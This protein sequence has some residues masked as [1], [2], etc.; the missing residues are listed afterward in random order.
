M[1]LILAPME[2]RMKMSIIRGVLNSNIECYKK[3]QEK[4]KE[5]VGDDRLNAQSWAEMKDNLDICYRFIVEGVLSAHESVMSDM[6]TLDG[7]IGNEY[8]DED[9][10]E[11]KKKLLE[12]ECEMYENNLRQLEFSLMA[13]VS[14]IL[15]ASAKE[16]LNAMIERTREEIAV[17]QEKINFL[18][19]AESSTKSLFMSALGLFETVANVIRDGKIVLNKGDVPIEPGWLKA[20]FISDC[21]EGVDDFEEKERVVDIIIPEEVTANINGNSV[22]YHP[23]DSWGVTGGAKPGLQKD[24]DGKYL[25]AVA[26]KIL[27]PDYPDDGK[28]WDDDFAN[29][30]HDIEV[31]L[32]NKVTGEKKVIE[33]VVTDIK[34]H[35]YNKY[36]DGHGYNTGDIVS[37]DIENGLIQTGIAYPKSYNGSKDKACSIQNMDA[38]IIEFVGTT[39][40]FK[41]DD[42]KL[43]K[44]IIKES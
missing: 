16:C 35:S 20:D 26:P 25:V 30:P 31:V 41:V 17:L 19:E 6:D 43:K 39:V 2:V 15:A 23:K 40:D 22:T 10:L 4:V 13:G 1:G 32:E 42:Y 11:T 12:K 38:S 18:K 7:A 29:V 9:E 21:V 14:G 37:Y 5:F 44:I 34:A 28:I 27:I 8:L 3:A 24:G 33:C 36:P